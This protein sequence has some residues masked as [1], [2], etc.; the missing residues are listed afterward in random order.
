MDFC[1]CRRDLRQSSKKLEG[2]ITV[3]FS[4]CFL[5]GVCLHMYDYKTH[6]CFYVNIYTL[7]HENQSAPKESMLV[8]RILICAIEGIGVYRTLQTLLV[9]N[10]STS[11]G[12]VK[13]LTWR[14]FKRTFIKLEIK[15]TIL[16]I[17]F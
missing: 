2:T 13:L 11:A 5:M 3:T 16:C 8:P 1:P 4:S 14:T 9:S 15:P 6:L 10:P 17:N 7:R 12:K